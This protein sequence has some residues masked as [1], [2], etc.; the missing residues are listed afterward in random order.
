M[1][2]HVRESHKIARIHILIKIVKHLDFAFGVSSIRDEF[3]PAMANGFL[4]RI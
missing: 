3:K 4:R 2:F 1:Q